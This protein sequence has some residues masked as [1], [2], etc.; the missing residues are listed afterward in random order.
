MDSK[1]SAWRQIPWFQL[2]HCLSACPSISVFLS[3]SLHHNIFVPEGITASSHFFPLT[4]AAHNSIGT[5]FMM[6]APIVSVY[7]CLELHHRI[8]CCCS[9]ILGQM[10]V[11]ESMRVCVCA[12]INASCLGKWP[13]YRI[14]KPKRSSY[15]ISPLFSCSVS[16]SLSGIEFLQAPDRGTNRAFTPRHQQHRGQ[17]DRQGERERARQWGVCVR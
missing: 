16:P 9:G 10:S 17:R 8:A 14:D 2:K 11:Y 3:H 1:F 7:C 12:R 6:A 5:I 15:P 4:E 13:L